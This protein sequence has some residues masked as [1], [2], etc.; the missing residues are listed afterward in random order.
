MIKSKISAVISAHNPRKDYFPKVLEGLRNQTM[1]YD[2]WELIIIDNLSTEK[3]TDL[4][5]ID[6]HP[7]Y[8]FLI[9]ENLGLAHA[10]KRGFKE[11]Q[12]S[13]LIN[14]DDDIIL[15]PKYLENAWKIYNKLPFIGVFGCQIQPDFE[16]H[17]KLKIEYYGNAQRTVDDDIWSNNIKEYKS[18]PFGAG[19]CLRNEVYKAYLQVLETDEFRLQLGRKGKELLSCEDI[20]I[21][22]FTCQMGLGKGMFKDLVITHFVPKNKMTV[23]YLIKNTYWNMYSATYQNHYLFNEKPAKL[24]I[25]HKLLRFLRI[26]RMDGFRRKA[27]FAKIKGVK[28]S[29]SKIK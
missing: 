1:P 19:M 24:S 18:T 8:K 26:I 21:V 10:R 16:E 28:D 29:W 22:F 11:A 4:Y 12:G 5:N 13:L 23:D 15:H 7:N 9:E 6:W 17:P 27:E 2:E 14:I 3:L 25:L 20:D